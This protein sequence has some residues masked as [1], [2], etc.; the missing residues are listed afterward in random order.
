M[1]NIRRSNMTTKRLHICITGG[2]WVAVIMA[3]GVTKGATVGELR[4]EFRVNPLGIDVDRPQLGWIIASDRRG[5]RQTA[6]QILAAGSPD[7]L[8]SGIGDLSAVRA[9]AAVQFRRIA[10][11]REIRR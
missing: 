8:G 2:F 6:Y 10:V 4:C 3:L 11:A 5:D 1:I 7:K 9:I